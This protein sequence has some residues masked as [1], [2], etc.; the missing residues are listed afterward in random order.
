[1]SVA[2]LLRPCIDAKD[3]F[4]S[5]FKEYHEEGRFLDRSIESLQLDFKTFVENLVED[6][7][8]PETRFADWVERVP[9][10]VLWFVKDDTYYGSLYIR[11][12]LN[13][14]LEKRGGHVSFLIRPSMR[15]QGFGKKI[16]Q[17]GIPAI[18]SLGIEKALLTVEPDNMAAMR[19]V[20]FCGADFERQTQETERFPSRLLYW[21]DCT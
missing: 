15:N 7:D 3:S 4:I 13:W 17:R 11:H 19:I 10:T 14:H 2:Q 20:E 1:M 12:R 21:L 6:R 5:A 9:E 8:Q 16:L 18:N